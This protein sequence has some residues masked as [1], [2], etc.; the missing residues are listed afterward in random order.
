VK[1][2]K[3]CANCR[4][5]LKIDLVKV[6]LEMERI[7]LSESNRHKGGRPSKLTATDQHD[8]KYSHGNGESMGKLAEKYGVSRSTIFNIVHS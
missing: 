3:T 5:V 6:I 2:L 1:D 7:Y 4:E 8:I